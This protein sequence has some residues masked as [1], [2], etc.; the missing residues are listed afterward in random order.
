MP[1]TKEKSGGAFLLQETKPVKLVGSLASGVYCD[2]RGWVHLACFQEPG[3]LTLTRA[4]GRMAV[5]MSRSIAMALVSLLHVLVAQIQQLRPT[6]PPDS[7]R[8]PSAGK[9]EISV[10][11]ERDEVVISWG[12]AESDA[13]LSEVE[14]QK[15]LRMS[16][17]F[18]KGLA[19]DLAN[20][21]GRFA[22][23][24]LA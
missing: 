4:G 6:T 12:E 3:H 9:S 13:A 11:V 19:S 7:T 17:G 18:A 1:V 2:G 16:E 23:R 14:G 15:E 20:E 24:T 10:L 5:T 21:I 22:G 8:V